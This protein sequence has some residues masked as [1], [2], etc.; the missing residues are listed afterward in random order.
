MEGLLM[1][2]LI[3]KRK[4][5]GDP[6]PERGIFGEAA[7]EATDCMGKVRGYGFDAVIGVGG[8]G[9]EPRLKGIARKL[10]WVGV[11]VHKWGEDLRGPRVK[12]DHFWCRDNAGPYLKNIAP[13]LAHY[14]FDSKN[15]R[16]L[17]H[18]LHE[19]P[20][21]WTDADQELSKFLRLRR[22]QDNRRRTA[23]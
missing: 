9:P 2:I 19:L 14:I 3:Y 17:I 1:R 15:R 21:R 12:F 5:T 20:E 11:G 7:D 22:R 8:I 4:H 10:T 23:K 18:T 16:H 13:N 6:D